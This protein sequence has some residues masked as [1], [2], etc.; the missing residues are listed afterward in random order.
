MFT[1]WETRNRYD[2]IDPSGGRA[3]IAGETGAGLGALLLR[4]LFRQRR[5]FTIEVRTL[6]GEPVLR[7]FRPWTWLLSRA[8]VRDGTGGLLGWIRQ[9]LAFLSRRYTVFDETGQVALE[10]HGPF[11]RPWTFLIVQG[12]IEAGA[13]RKRWSGLLN[14]AFTSADRFG[15]HFGPVLTPRQRALALAATFLIDYVHFESRS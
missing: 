13:I 10:I 8:E 11:F 14:E 9:R 1:G 7:L 4:Q 5:P 12:G 3:F 15:V 2:I 6:S